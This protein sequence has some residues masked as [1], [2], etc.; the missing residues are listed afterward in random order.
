MNE[1][2]SQILDFIVSTVNPLDDYKEPDELPEVND[3]VV[4]GM[5]DSIYNTPE[6]YKA[7]FH[8]ISDRMDE[9]IAKEQ[10]QGMILRKKLD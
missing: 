1:K 5:V 9:G 10:K 2:L 7:P 4:N 8:T 3:E 6:D